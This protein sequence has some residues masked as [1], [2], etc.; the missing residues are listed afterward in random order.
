MSPEGSF[1][2]IQDTTAQMIRQSADKSQTGRGGT[3]ECQTSGTSA[4]E[5][6]PEHTF[7]WDIVLNIQGALDALGVQ[8]VLSRNNDALGSCVD[9]RAGSA[10][11]IRPDAIVSI[12]ADGGPQ[13]GEVF[14]A[15]IRV[16]R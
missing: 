3:K 11:A 14:T 1:S 9:E 16:R 7:N 13:Q 5:G 4:N 15:T 10:N 6:Y 2:S 8:T 12:H